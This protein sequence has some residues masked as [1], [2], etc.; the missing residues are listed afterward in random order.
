M[1]D[2]SKQTSV[3][4]RLAEIEKLEKLRDSDSI[5]M[6]F[7]MLGDENWEVGHA[8]GKAIVRIGGPEIVSRLFEALNSSE[9]SKS[10]RWQAASS[11]GRIGGPEITSTLLEMV[12]SAEPETTSAVISELGTIGDRIAVP[13]LIAALKTSHS[14]VRESAAR[15]LGKLK[16]ICAVPALV[17]AKI[18]AHLTDPE[19]HSLSNT[20][21]DALKQLGD[22][23]VL[24]VIDALESGDPST[25]L[26]VAPTL[27]AL[28]GLG[29]ARAVPALE[30]AL[31]AEDPELRRTAAS[32]LGSIGVPSSC[33]SL[34]KAIND[35][36]PEV[37]RAAA[38][39]LGEL[40]DPASQASLIRAWHDPDDTVAFYAG[41]ALNSIADDSCTDEIVAG[42]QSKNP[43]M[44]LQAIEILGSIGNPLAIPD[45]LQLL[46]DTVSDKV[47]YQVIEALGKIGDQSIV[48]RLLSGLIHS[49]PLIRAITARALGLIG[50]PSATEALLP[51]LRDPVSLVRGWTARALG[52]IGDPRALRRL[53]KLTRDEAQYLEPGVMYFTPP[54]VGSDAS[55][56]VDRIKELKLLHRI[57]FS[58]YSPKDVAHDTW[59]TVHIY[60]SGAAAASAVEADARTQMGA[61]K[62]DFREGGASPGNPIARGAEVTV[63]PQLE[64]FEFNPAKSTIRFC[65]DWHRLDFRT[66]AG[67][68]LVGR[69]S[70]GN[71]TFRVEG[72]IAATVPVSIYVSDSGESVD[73]MTTRSTTI[74]AIFCSY[75]HRDRRVAGHIEQV[76][77]AL[78]IEYLRDIASLRSGQKWRD[79]LFRLIDRADLFQLLWSKNAARSKAV[80][81]E[82]KYAAHL[83]RQR[84]SF[85]RPVY[86]DEP[87]H[88]PPT[89]LQSIHFAYEPELKNVNR[90]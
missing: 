3:S 43:Q 8:A 2:K 78:G 85:I 7:T 86:W 25:R 58:V 51:G 19:N 21:T 63:E 71:V 73:T 70:N 88:P 55:S 64:G 77:R 75:S 36:V 26:A 62:G 49:H 52:Q 66:R 57:E 59:N 46:E 68:E 54:R 38:Q 90:D 81:E 4:S 50:H 28:S 79:E 10:K 44:Q 65:E 33:H 39:A 29:D 76:C 23:A 53:E 24:A 82:W 45:L 69:A 37:R 80:E 6:L 56:A 12:E 34:S 20:I 41:R 61:R 35:T 13:K 32:V 72:V 30:R 17:V 42:L 74:Q 1:S 60:V 31:G 47:R 18:D 87:M 27:Y 48:P 14:M 11:L 89:E 84:T 15:A 83:S 5:E 22:T 16:D 40:R 9:S 67:R